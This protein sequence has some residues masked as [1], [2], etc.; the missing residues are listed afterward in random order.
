[1]SARNRS[2]GDFRTC[3]GAAQNVGSR[4][5]CVRDLSA[6]DRAVGYLGCGNGR[7]RDVRCCDCRASDL[8][9]CHCTVFKGDRIQLATNTNV[10]KIQI[11]R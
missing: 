4:N 11:C 5:R 8:T 6:C 3:Y 9:A 2:R 1:M 7:I 10:V